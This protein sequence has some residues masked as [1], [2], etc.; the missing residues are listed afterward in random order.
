[1][2]GKANDE[3]KKI[4]L[5]LL[6]S[7]S[8]DVHEFHCILISFPLNIITKAFSELCASASKDNVI[9]LEKS[10]N[11]LGIMIKMVTLM[12][13]KKHL[14]SDSGLG[15]SKHKNYNKSNGKI[16]KIHAPDIERARILLENNTNSDLPPAQL[17]FYLELLS[18]LAHDSSF[19]VK[20]PSSLL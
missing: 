8:D 9:E 1:M 12:L 6:R 16:I 4:A 18:R 5:E 17:I 13:L 3:L 7:N 10:F 15:A 20:S 2:E 14:T 11:D 19:T